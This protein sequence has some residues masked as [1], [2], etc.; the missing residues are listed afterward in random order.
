MVVV[1][2]IL[3]NH[4]IHKFYTCETEPNNPTLIPAG[5]ESNLY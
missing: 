2:L 3:L 4:Y 5:E 1:F